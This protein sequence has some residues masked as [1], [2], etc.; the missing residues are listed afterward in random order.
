MSNK[1]NLTL[2]QQTLFFLLV[3][4]SELSLIHFTPVDLNSQYDRVWVMKN[5]PEARKRRQDALKEQLVALYKDGYSYREMSKLLKI[6]HEWA[7]KLHR[8]TL[9]PIILLTSVD[10]SK[11]KD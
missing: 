3:M 6:S 1:N 5:N 9:I 10:S 7:R 4:V 11:P 8:D 2:F